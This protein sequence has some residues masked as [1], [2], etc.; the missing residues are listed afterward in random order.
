ML[1]RLESLC[2]FGA[3]FT[4][5]GT[6]ITAGSQSALSGVLANVGVALLGTGIGSAARGL[7]WRRLLGRH[8]IDPNA[9]VYYERGDYARIVQNVEQAERLDLLGISL[10]YAIE[11]I[12]DN[13]AEYIRRV[14]HTRILLPASRAIC[15]GRDEAQGTSPGGLWVGVRDSHKLIRRLIEDHPTSFSVRFFDIQ[16]Y[17]A[18]TRV[19]DFIWASPYVTLSGR[20]CPVIALQKKA[21]PELYR[22]FATHFELM[23]QR[24]SPDHNESLAGPTTT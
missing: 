8:A 21:S 5:T 15:D 23:W 4:L 7:Q 12:K 14:D 1:S 19:D 3:A 11:Y 24:S 22:T 6:W 10:S 17:C 13:T 20:S 18:L 9:L 16:P 2:F